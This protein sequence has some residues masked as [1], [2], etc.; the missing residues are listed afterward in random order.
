MAHQYSKNLSHN[1]VAAWKNRRE[2]AREGAQPMPAP[3]GFMLMKMGSR[4]FTKIASP[5]S[6]VS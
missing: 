1:L 2:K 4:R 5:S 6:S 3:S